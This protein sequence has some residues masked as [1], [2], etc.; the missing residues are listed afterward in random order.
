[1]LFGF[2]QLVLH[3]HGTCETWEF[4]SNFVNSTAFPT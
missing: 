4:D 1:M 2:A 3:S